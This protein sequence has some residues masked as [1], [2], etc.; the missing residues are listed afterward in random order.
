MLDFF[1]ILQAMKILS[2]KRLIKK[3][4]FYRKLSKTW[5]IGMMMSEGGFTDGIL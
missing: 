3:A 1:C 2:K 4:G 5:L